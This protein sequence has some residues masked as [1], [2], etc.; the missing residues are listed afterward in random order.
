MEKEDVTIIAQLLTSMKDAISK[1]EDA[2]KKKN[3]A[4]TNMA[5]REILRLKENLDGLL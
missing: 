3:M 2:L 1:L 5:K 4:E